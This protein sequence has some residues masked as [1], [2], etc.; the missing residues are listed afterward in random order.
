MPVERFALPA[1]MSID[2]GRVR[3][4]WEQQLQRLFEDMKD[5]PGVDK[6]REL[7]LKTVMKPVVNEAGEL[8]SVEVEFEIKSGEPRRLSNKYSMKAGRSGLLFNEFAP[9]N[10]DQMTF[11]DRGEVRDAR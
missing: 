11:G 4:A 2:D 1:L 10:A 9:E 7:T 8:E 3:L 5:R 6:A